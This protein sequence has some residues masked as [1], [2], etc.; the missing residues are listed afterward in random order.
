MPVC[1]KRRMWRG[2][3]VVHVRKTRTAVN[4]EALSSRMTKV[5]GKRRRMAV[6]AE[7][8]TPRSSHGVGVA[9]AQL[10]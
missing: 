9:L 2:W 10:G 7:L 8:A 6:R 1:C 5:A 4:R 3:V